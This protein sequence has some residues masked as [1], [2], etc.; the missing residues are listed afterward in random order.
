MKTVIDV[1]EELESTGGSLA[2][3]SILEDNS[4][5]ELLRRVFVASQDPYTVYYVNKFK[6]PPAKNASNDLDDCIVDAFITGLDSMLATRMITG[7]SAKEWVVAKFSTMNERQQK[8]CQRIILKN[9]RV[10]V[11]ESTVNKVWPG[12]LKSFEVALA[13]TLSTT[14]TK[15]NGIKINERIAYPVRVDPKLDGL[16]CIAVKQEGVV[17]IY[18]RNGTVLDT[19]PT[20]TKA[21]E[22]ASYDNVVLDGEILA[23]THDWNTSVSVVMSRKEKKDDS[24][25]VYNVFDAVALEQWIA[26]NSTATYVARLNVVR[27]IVDAVNSKNVVAVEG[28]TVENEKELLSFYSESM[29]Q[30]HEG[31]MIKDLNAA[32]VFKRSRALMKMKPV[33]THE[34]V[35]ISTYEGRTGTKN[36]GMFGG[37]DCVSQN[38]IITRVGGGFNDAF[39]AEVQLN[40]PESYVGKV[41]EIEMQPDP[42]TTDGLSKDGKA[43]FPVFVRFRSIND[44]DKKL[45]ETATALLQ[46]EVV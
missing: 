44:V 18:T 13:Q 20:V 26:Q 29:S 30:G 33:M 4:R 5:N 41:I 34:M 32:Y 39:R 15:E 43:R 27:L 25:M 10:G 28:K 24:H 16:R 45:I 36:E 3:R 1:L 23:D 46:N 7:N 31:I 12:L 6:V 11:Q 8:W 22:E 42:L 19:L 40:G 38:G 17:T 21:L 9:L 2:K 35:I 14:C 37:F